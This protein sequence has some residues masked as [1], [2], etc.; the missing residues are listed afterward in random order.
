VRNRAIAIAAVAL[1]VG[2]AAGYAF[3][4]TTGGG[5]SDPGTAVA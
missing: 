5:S 2:A 1:L 3:G 4:S